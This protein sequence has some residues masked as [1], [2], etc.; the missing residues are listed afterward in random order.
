MPR[1]VIEGIISLGYYEHD[2]WVLSLETKGK[3]NPKIF[4]AIQSPGYQL[5]GFLKKG[6]NL[7][8]LLISD[9]HIW[10]LSAVSEEELYAHERATHLFFYW[11]LMTDLKVVIIIASS[12]IP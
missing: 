6:R 10:W 8:N 4:V 11:Y 9:G 1:V 5:K 2:P 12:S 7:Y 3:L